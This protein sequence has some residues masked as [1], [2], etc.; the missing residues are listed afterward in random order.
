MFIETF[1][2]ALEPSRTLDERHLS[3][4]GSMYTFLSFQMDVLTRRPTDNLSPD[5]RFA[6]A[7]VLLR[8]F[9]ENLRLKY[10]RVSENPGHW[11]QRP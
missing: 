7:S 3:R 6:G 9:Y 10:Y 8:L 1:I 4:D 2:P 5:L 11:L